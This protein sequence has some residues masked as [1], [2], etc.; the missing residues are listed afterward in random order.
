M[1]TRVRGIRLRPPLLNW[2]NKTN[3]PLRYQTTMSGQGGSLWLV[4]DPT[5]K[6]SSDLLTQMSDLAENRSW[7][8]EVSEAFNPHMTITSGIT[9]YF[10]SS[11]KKVEFPGYSF[12]SLGEVKIS[13]PELRVKEVVLGEQFL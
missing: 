1:N 8:T 10:L 13:P 2:T 6:C 12:I 11:C 9:D 7:G 5:S 4:P 3:D